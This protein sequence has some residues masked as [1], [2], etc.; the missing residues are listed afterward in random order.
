MKLACVLDVGAWATAAA[1]GYHVTGTSFALPA[2]C[3]N[4]EFQL[5][6]V[7]AH[8]STRMADDF[9]VRYPVADADDHGLA[10]LWMIKSVASL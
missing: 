5:N 7:K 10:C 8:A 2:L 4:T 1:L 3:G 6:F 9:T